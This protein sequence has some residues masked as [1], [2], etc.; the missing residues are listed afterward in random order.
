MLQPQDHVAR[1]LLMRADWWHELSAADHELLTGLGS[2]HEALFRW[3]DR[4]LTEHGPRPWPGLRDDVL[5]QP[6]GSTAAQLLDGAELP[7]EATLEELHA[8]LVQTARAVTAPE[9]AKLLGRH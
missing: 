6:W 1:M 7:V 9:I 8:A 4:D 5:Q 3:L 2:W